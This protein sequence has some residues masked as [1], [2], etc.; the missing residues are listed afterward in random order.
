MPPKEG[1]VAL[2][3]EKKGTAALVSEKKKE[4]GKEVKVEVEV[5]T[6]EK[7]SLALYVLSELA[8]IFCLSRKRDR[9]GPDTGGGVPHRERRK[10][11]ETKSPLEVRKKMCGQ[12]MRRK[13]EKKKSSSPLSLTK[14]SSVPE[15][16]TT[17]P[18]VVSPPSSLCLGFS[19][20][21]SSTN[22]RF[23]LA[24]SRE[25]DSRPRRGHGTQ[26]G[27]WLGTDE[28]P[29]CLSEM[30]RQTRRPAVAAAAAAATDLPASA[31]DLITSSP[32]KRRVAAVAAVGESFF[33]ERGKMVAALSKKKGC[34][35]RK[36]GESN[37]KVGPLFFI[38]RLLALRRSRA[39]SLPFALT[40][41][42]SLS[43]N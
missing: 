30:A 17:P 9:E 32:R 12:K 43:Q 8:I 16:E 6:K 33:A 31:A 22:E 19:S 29:T 38:S 15:R 1:A 11:L 39:F 18:R 42:C 27:L 4:E 34:H 3:S 10:R 28:S 23:D 5:E 25:S 24:L 13:K 7:L 2:I 35:L 37:E 20:P 40:S 26:R 14:L 21:F 36:K 41:S